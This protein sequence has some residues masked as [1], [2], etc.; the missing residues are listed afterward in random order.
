MG[1]ARP[2]ASGPNRRPVAR[3]GQARR[4]R[5]RAAPAAWNSQAR[6]A[7]L[8][9][10]RAVELAW[11]CIDFTHPSSPTSPASTS[12]WRCIVPRLFRLP[13]LSATMENVHPLLREHPR[14]ERVR[15][16]PGGWRLAVVTVCFGAFMGQLDASITTLAY[17]ALRT[18][19]GVSLAAVSWVSLSYLLT[20][21]LLLVPVGRL[22]DAFGPK[23]FYVYRFRAFTAASAACALAPS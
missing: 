6:Q 7:R 14:P 5:S 2:L 17:P 21:T 4:P 19:F 1:Q 11:P 3:P 20:L 9:R 12:C 13:K 8:C 10:V 23:L 22:S 15:R 16:M 18:E